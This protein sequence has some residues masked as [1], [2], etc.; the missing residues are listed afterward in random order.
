LVKHDPIRGIEET[1]SKKESV[2]PTGLVFDPRSQGIFLNAQAGFLQLFDPQKNSMIFNVRKF[3]R[4]VYQ[5]MKLILFK[6]S[7]WTL[8]IAMF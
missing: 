5:L 8:P 7:S 6:F 3:V 2:M 1:E 4:Q